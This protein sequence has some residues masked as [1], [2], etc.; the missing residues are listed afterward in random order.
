MR[1]EIVCNQ[2][3]ALCKQVGHCFLKIQN[4]LLNEE[5]G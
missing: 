4:P 3:W 5:P 2:D 1:Q